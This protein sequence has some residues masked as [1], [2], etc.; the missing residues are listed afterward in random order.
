MGTDI[1]GLKE[2]IANGTLILEDIIGIQTSEIIVDSAKIKCDK[3]LARGSFRPTNKSTK[4]NC[5]VVAT[6]KDINI[7]S[8]GMCYVTGK[9]CL[10]VPTE[11]QE[12]GPMKRDDAEYLSRHSYMLCGLDGKIEFVT[13]ESHYDR[14]KAVEFAKKWGMN[15]R[16]WTRANPDFNRHNNNCTNFISQCL[17]IGGIPMDEDWHSYTLRKANGFFSP[18]FPRFTNEY[19]ETM[20]WIHVDYLYVYIMKNNLYTDKVL[21]NSE[22]MAGHAKYSDIQE[23]DFMFIISDD[24]TARNK[25][26][27]NDPFLPALTHVMI[28]TEVDKENGIFRYCGNSNDASNKELTKDLINDDTWIVVKMKD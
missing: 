15:G 24:T 9:R 14:K 16:W 21:I 25:T 27:P 19:D 10:P 26:N 28:V 11:W 6:K 3:G 1:K 4:I 17:Y 2:A 8:F 23:G 12:T 20:A 13:S 5:S 7:P 18:I 22:T